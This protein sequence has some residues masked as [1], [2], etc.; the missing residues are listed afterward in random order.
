MKEFYVEIV[1]TDTGR[2]S[3]RMGPMSEHSADKTSEGA[4]INLNH[5]A[6]HVRIV[7]A[8]DALHEEG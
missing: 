5:D 7:E 1:Q 2:V 6:Y 8:K 3:K 4:M